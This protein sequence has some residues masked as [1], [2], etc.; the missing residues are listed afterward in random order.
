MWGNFALFFAV[1]G[2]D[3]RDLVH[4]FEVQNE[5]IKCFLDCAICVDVTPHEFGY[6]RSN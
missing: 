2:E 6:M 3:L 4:S 1:W 5:I